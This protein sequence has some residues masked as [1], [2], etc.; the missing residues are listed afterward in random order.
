MGEFNSAWYERKKSLSERCQ[1][2][3]EEA[4]ATAEAGQRR[5]NYTLSSNR[6]K[7]HD[8]F[9]HHCSRLHSFLEES[10][11]SKREKTQLQDNRFQTLRREILKTPCSQPP[12]GHDSQASAVRNMGL[13]WVNHGRP[14]VQSYSPTSE[15]GSGSR[16]WRNYR[17]HLSVKIQTSSS[18]KEPRA[19]PQAFPPQLSM[20]VF[21]CSGLRAHNPVSTGMILWM[22]STC[23]VLLKVP[24]RCS[25]V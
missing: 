4:G 2:G 22:W 24:H 10:K 20:G 18:S 7:T 16:A 1:V 3:E 8:W 25:Y 14:P 17:A 9:W 23:K 19:C 6:F 13:S 21:A 5:G 11:Q 12:S 15:Q